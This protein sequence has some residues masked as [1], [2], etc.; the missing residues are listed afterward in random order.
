ME[1]T[2][3]SLIERFIDRLVPLIQH[4]NEYDFE[5]KVFRAHKLRDGKLGLIV[6]IADLFRQLLLDESWEYKF[7]AED[8]MRFIV[9]NPKE[10]I[11]K[12]LQQTPEDYD[13]LYLGCNLW[14]PLIHKHSQNLIQVNDVYALHSVIYSRKGMQKVLNEIHQMVNIIA[15][16]VLIKEKILP[17]GK[18]YCSFPMLTKQVESY[19]DI[20]NKIVN[21]DKVLQNRFNQRTRHLL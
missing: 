21:Y 13:M 1:I 11:E 18:S 17:D 6:T 3:V 4:L 5:Y 9:S 16:D 15:L 7:I 12:C 10:I 19:S 8:D 2:I 14:Q 20:E